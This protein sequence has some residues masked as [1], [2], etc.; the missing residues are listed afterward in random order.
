MT[1]RYSE[2][3]ATLAKRQFHSNYLLLSTDACLLELAKQLLIRELESA[4]EA[5]A[6]VTALDLDET[7]VEELLNAAQSFSMFAPRQVIVVHG[8]MKLRET[9]G[10]RLA[11]YFADPNPQTMLVF[12]AGELDRDQ[13]KKKIF[14]ILTAGAKV[15][16]LAPLDGG[17]AAQWLQRRAQQRGCAI[18]PDAVRFL[19]E[20]QGNDLGRL[21]Q[22]LEKA[23]LY[24][25]SEK[26]ITLGM[27]EAVSGFAAGHTLSE[28]IGAIVSKNHVK[29]LG[30]VGEIFF[31]GRETGLAFWWFGQQLRQWLQFQELAGR[32]PTG[33]IGRRVGVFYPS[34]ASRIEKQSRG[35][36]RQSLLR[37]LSRLA[38]V[39]DKLKSSSVDTRFTM[40]LLVHELAS[41][42]WFT[43]PEVPMGGP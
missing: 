19:L 13:R 30:L 28:F 21:Q 20:L 23:L 38:A 36:S 24:A 41:Q 14:E 35:F 33:E 22:E 8:V 4:S 10:R 15:V 32:V 43:P 18:E 39:D 9:Q 42:T 26:Q 16:E 34:V 7:P 29:A 37:A 25:G 3:E 5:Q 11:Q 17:E 2:F 12:L 31:T 6:A 27:V 40:E 1:I